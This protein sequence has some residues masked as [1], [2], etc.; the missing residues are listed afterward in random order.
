MSLSCRRQV[1]FSTLINGRFLDIDYLN[2]AEP[3]P[4]ISNPKFQAPNKFQ[5]PMT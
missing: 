5:A 2:F 4:S 3:E 1:I